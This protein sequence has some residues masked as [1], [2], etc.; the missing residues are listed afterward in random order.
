MIEMFLI[1]AD[2]IILPHRSYMSKSKLILQTSM[3]YY[4]AEK[5]KRLIPEEFFTSLKNLTQLG[6]KWPILQAAWA[7]QKLP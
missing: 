2:N 3:F 5:W 7:R 1:V 4:S 6:C